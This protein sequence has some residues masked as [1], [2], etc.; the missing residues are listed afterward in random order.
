MSSGGTPIPLPNEQ[1]LPSGVTA[2]SG[3]TVFTVAEAGTY[4]ISYHVNTTLALSMGTRLVINSISHVAS[5]IAPKIN[6]SR[7][8]NQITVYLPANSTISL[9]MYPMTLAG[10]AVLVGGGAGASL[11]IIRLNGTKPETP[12][13][14]DVEGGW[15][16]EE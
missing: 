12:P 15:D 9:Q 5:T 10:G 14:H 16:Y 11:T 1:V 4:Q 6:T 7:F 13:E 2:N 3:N 8:E